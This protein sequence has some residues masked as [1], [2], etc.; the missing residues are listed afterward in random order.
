MSLA[1]RTRELAQSENVSY[2]KSSRMTPEHFRGVVGVEGVL[3]TF[4]LLVSRRFWY[5][6][7]VRVLAETAERIFALRIVLDAVEI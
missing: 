5:V 6:R 2:D 3:G 7:N 4:F 1:T